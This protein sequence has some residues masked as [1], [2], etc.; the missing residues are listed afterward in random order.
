MKSGLVLS[1][2]ALIVLSV[3]A[4][5][6]CAVRQEDAVAIWL[7]DEGS[8]K[9]VKDSSIPA[10]SHGS[11]VGKLEWAEG[12]NGKG[13]NFTGE[14]G[15]YVSIPH[16]N[17]MNLDEFSIT[18]WVKLEPRA[19]DRSGHWQPFMIK[20][21]DNGE[22][23]YSLMAT[24]PGGQP[25][26][27]F[28]VGGGYPALTGAN[29]IVDAEWHHVVGTYEEGDGFKLYVDGEPDSQAPSEGDLPT[30]DGDII[31]GNNLSGARGIQGVI[32]E[33]GLFKVALTEDDVKTIFL[34]GL[35]PLTPVESS[36]K[37]VDK[38]GSIKN[39]Y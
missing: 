9:A 3:F 19:G 12:K 26:V 21:G 38:W 31:I 23:N 32:D 34:N 6:V 39:F 29:P 2:T 8:G 18:A 28:S 1:F 25:Y 14:D 15:S 17:V 36:G 4:G 22:R 16:K 35:E 10:E 7:F 20:E 30:N 5:S 24:S 11:L 27:G 37:L 13:I 33:I